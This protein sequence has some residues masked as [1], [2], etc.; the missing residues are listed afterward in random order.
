MWSVIY[1]Y[2]VVKIEV[3][4]ILG[5]MNRQQMDKKDVSRLPSDTRRQEINSKQRQR[6]HVV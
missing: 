6:N 3:E 1:G 2:E 4:T 5:P